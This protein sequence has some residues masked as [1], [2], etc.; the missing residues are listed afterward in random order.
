[1][2]RILKKLFILIIL[3]V[4]VLLIVAGS[5]FYYYQS[6]LNYH[7][8]SNEKISFDVAKNEGIDSITNKLIS[9]GF[10]SEKW[11]WQVYLKLNPGLGSDI[12]AGNFTLN[13]NMS[14]PDI[15]Q[16][17][18]KANINIG[19]K[20]TVIEGLRYD[21]IA[22]AVDKGFA[23]SNKNNFSKTDFI[24]IA[25]NPG[26]VTFT[27]DVETFLAKN[28][29]LKANL[30]G[31]LFPETYYFD[32]GTNAQKVIEKM[33]LTLSQELTDSDYQAIYSSNYS[34]QQY[35]TVASLIQRETL[36]VAEKPIVAD[37]IYKR[38]ENGINGVKLLQLDSTLLYIL[39]DWNAAGKINEALKDKYKTNPYNTYRVVGLPPTPIANPGL[40]SIKA[41]IY[42]QKND[43]YY[44][45]HDSS[46]VIHY[47]RTLSEHNANVNKYL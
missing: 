9:K 31:Y 23:G 19:V 18:Q 15:F 13:A 7:K 29:P 4:V 35:L 32:E 30:E 8:A 17:L 22:D 16:A 37:I 25:E 12:Q 47:G 10:V 36:T 41:A 24:K 2:L 34:F 1:M 11:V 46:G 26:T 5:A 42:P 33:I 38:L 14:I 20:I 45:L 3:L 21:E 44:Y 6:K 39:K 43:Y 28:K 27:P 40:D